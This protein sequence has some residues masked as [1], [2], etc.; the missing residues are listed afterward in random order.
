MIP[1]PD[2]DYVESIRPRGGFGKQNLASMRASFAATKRYATAKL[3]PAWIPGAEPWEGAVPVAKVLYSFRHPAEEDLGV[4]LG[5]HSS[6][7][8]G[9]DVTPL[10]DSGKPE[11]TMDTER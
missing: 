4:A 6:A 3:N 2:F 11:K 9:D 7:H 10:F 8:I 1:P 5:G